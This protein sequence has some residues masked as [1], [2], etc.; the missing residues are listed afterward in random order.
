MRE[1]MCPKRGKSTRGEASVCLD[2]SKIIK[3]L[4][5]VF[6]GDEKKG[7]KVNG[8]YSGFVKVRN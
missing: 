8:G 7:K 6:I 5:M 1:V 3:C 2:Y 4:N